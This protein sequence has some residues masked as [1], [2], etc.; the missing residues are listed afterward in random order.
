MSRPLPPHLPDPLPGPAAGLPTAYY[1]SGDVLRSRSLA[2][3]ALVARLELPAPPA[4]VTADWQHEV[5]QRLGLEPGDVEPL[6][7]ARTRLRWPALRQCV[8]A[9]AEWTRSLGLQELLADSEQALMACRGARYHHDA[10][11]YGGMAFCNLFL[12]EDRGLDLHFPASGQ[13]IPLLRGTAV[14]FDTG[15]P[16]AV[17]ARRSDGFVLAD[18]AEGQDCDQ[19]FLSWELPIEDP[20]LARVLG[21]GFDTD[22]AKALLLQEEQLLLNGAPVRLCPASGRWISDGGAL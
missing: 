8:Q 6:P 12:S 15:T 4:S 2:P 19:V 9:M 3:R 1:R 22:P 10:V 14:L 7:L 13:R 20:Q 16:H 21:I 18:F 17:I 5:H 11:Q